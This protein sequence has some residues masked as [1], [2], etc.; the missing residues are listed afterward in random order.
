MR[1]ELIGLWRE[2]DSTG[3]RAD[4]KLKHTALAVR[5]ARKRANFSVASVDDTANWKER[6]AAG[7]PV[8]IFKSFSES[9]FDG[10]DGGRRGDAC[11]YVG[12][13]LWHDWVVHAQRYLW[14][15]EWA[16]RKPVTVPQTGP[17]LR[18]E[19]G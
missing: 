7:L 6:G 19:S 2:H 8:S 17:E 5:V 13:A 4:P 10:D 3:L 18:P 9:L 14:I 12:R 1:L 16:Q 15:P 11:A